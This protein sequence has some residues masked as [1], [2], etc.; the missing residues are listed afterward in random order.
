MS[1]FEQNFH[2]AKEKLA[3]SQIEDI[4][5][6]LV[7]GKD[8]DL[9]NLPE[10]V[11]VNNFLPFFAGESVPDNI[12]LAA[13]VGIAGNPFKSVRI[14]TN[15]NSAILYTVPPLFDRDVIDPTKAG[16]NASPI[17]HV[18]ISTEQLSHNS[19]SMATRY[20]A[21][22]LGKRNLLTDPIAQMTKHAKQ[23]NDIFQRYGMLENM[24][25]LSDSGAQQ[26]NESDK[27]Q[28]TYDE[29]IL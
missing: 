23:W 22:E 5:K 29:D 10:H 1:D 8:E 17:Q 13:W 25:K 26:V 15:D 12:N 7:L 19:P 6:S 20:M 11:F 28:L 9:V 21:R 18:M 14:V 4:Y 3:S 16:E 24:I 27:I 2:N